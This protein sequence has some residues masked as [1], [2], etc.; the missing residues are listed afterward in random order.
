M[1]N[2]RQRRNRLDTTAHTWGRDARLSR[3]RLAHG[4]NTAAAMSCDATKTPSGAHC[5][6]CSA[7][8]MTTNDIDRQVPFLERRETTRAI[9][10][11]QL[12]KGEHPRSDACCTVLRELQAGEE[13]H[14]ARVVFHE[15]VSK[16]MR[17]RAKSRASASKD[18]GKALSCCRTGDRMLADR[19]PKSALP[20]DVHLSPASRRKRCR[21]PRRSCHRSHSL[22]R[23]TPDRS[24]RRPCLHPG[25]CA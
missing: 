6:A 8:F 19:A 14:P 15:C 25:R 16:E 11:A 9:S 7:T 20:G 4:D 18:D 23:A 5:A 17:T 10:P 12:A 2:T 22:P 1:E 13:T 24:R 21:R 3:E